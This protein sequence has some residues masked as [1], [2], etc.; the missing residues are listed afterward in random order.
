[1]LHSQ[2]KYDAWALIFTVQP[3]LQAAEPEAE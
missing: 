3:H 1:M 2:H